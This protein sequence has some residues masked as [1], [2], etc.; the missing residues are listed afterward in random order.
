VPASGDRA[1]LALAAVGGIAALTPP[2]ERTPCP[3]ASAVATLA[4]VLDTAP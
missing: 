2:D 1:W 4:P 3:A